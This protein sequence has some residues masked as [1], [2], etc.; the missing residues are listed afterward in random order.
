LKLVE[1]PIIVA[2]DGPGGVGKSTV[3]KA[4]ARQLQI[5]YLETGA[6]YRALGLKVLEEQVDP[7]DEEG[8]VEVAGRL[9]LTIVARPDG[10]AEILLDREP[11]GER[12]RDESVARI[13]SKVAA[14]PAVR[15]RLVGLQRSF[16]NEVGG[17][18]EG[19]DIGS[20]VFPETPFKFFLDAD[21]RVRAE[22]RLGEHRARGRVDASVEELRREI[23]AR[24]R[25]D[26]ERAESPL[27]KDASYLTI[28]TSG[29]TAE[30][31]SARVI[32]EIE[33]LR[34]ESGASGVQSTFAE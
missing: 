17:V 3:A 22:R 29:M 32:A 2:I 19:R 6:M 13:T 8:V 10:S 34:R 15:R 25:R 12:V 7:E 26:S 18:V 20:R 24:D 28:D 16:G 5:P 30:Q 27:R 31:V 9:D 23:E 1:R 4:V 11:L 33:R 14:Y 21:P